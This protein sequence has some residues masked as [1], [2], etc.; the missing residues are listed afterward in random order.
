MKK[1]RGIMRYVTFLLLAFLNRSLSAAQEYDAVYGDGAN[2]ITLSTGSPGELGLVEALAT[3]FNKKHDTTIRWTKAGSGKALRLLREKKVDVVLVHAPEAEKRAIAEGWAV[4]HTLIGSNEF[5]I[6]GPKDDPADVREAASAGEAYAR[7]AKSEA[8]FLS[9]GDNSGTH[10]KEMA[11]WRRAGI[12]PYGDWYLLTKDFMLATLREAN[13]KKAYFMTDSS[14]WVPAR[15][16]LDDLE[17]LFRGDPVLVNAYH[18]LCQPEGATK[19][20][21]HASKFVDF[22]STAEAQATVRNYGKDRYGEPM[23]RNAREAKAFT[24]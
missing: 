11:I 14:T 8:K 19:G 3:A 20:Q 16:E 15:A 7:I 10:K 17:V 23:Y 13:R 4:K 2:T 18:A 9:R 1:K 5:Y 22:L 24:H 21:T 12:M 6:V